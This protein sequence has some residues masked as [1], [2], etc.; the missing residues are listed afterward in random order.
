MK[1]SRYNR[2]VHIEDEDRYLLFNGVTTGLVS[3]D[4]ELFE[5]A[6]EIMAAA[7]DGGYVP[8]GEEDRNIY[9]TL[10][11]GRFIVPKS[12]DELAL[13]KVRYNVSRFNDPL[14]L[15]ILPTMA[16]NLECS[17]CY[18]RPKSEF[19]TQ[20]TVD[21]VCA[22]VEERAQRERITKL[23]V[24]WYGGE[25]LLAAS[26]IWGLSESFMKLSEQ[27]D[28]RYGAG[29]TTNGTLLTK[30]VVDNLLRYNVKSVQVT[31]DGPKEVHDGRRPFKSA[32]GSSFDAIMDNLDYV[33]G[34]LR[35]TLRINTDMRNAGAAIDLLEVF[36]DRGWLTEGNRF[37]PYMAPVSAMTEV[38]A[39]VAHECCTAES[40]FDLSMDFFK[41]CTAHGVPVKTHALYHF[42]VSPKYVCG[43]VALNTMVVNP[44]GE[45]HKCGLTVSDNSESLGNIR[46]PMD[47][48]N[49][50]LLKWLSYDPFDVEECR[51]CDLLPICFGGCPKRVL[52]GEYPAQGKSCE[53]T[54]KNT[55]SILILHGA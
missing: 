47:L 4:R 37:Y 48:V 3:L 17:Y 49:P 19:M 41:A 7:D 45:I 12:V 33:V 36:A 50:N 38:C 40:F 55:D 46:E 52:E 15:T 24:S 53:C 21:A 22:F 28:F 35:V 16:C 39:D 20:E 43:A 2:I 14:S 27:H 6:Q 32:Q 29:M 1:R 10:V 9:T 5:K 30:D 25:P 11:N 54:K 44:S 8:E 26:T 51:Q 31:V 13:L 18:E 34:R 23:N 42:P